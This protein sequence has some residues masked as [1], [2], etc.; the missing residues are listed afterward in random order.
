MALNVDA[1]QHAL[2]YVVIWFIQQLAYTPYLYMSD[3]F[4][5][6]AIS[7]QQDYQQMKSN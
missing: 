3:T 6:Q 7:L 2:V 1:P 4:P 5:V